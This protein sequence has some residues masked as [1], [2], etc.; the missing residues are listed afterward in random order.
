MLRLLIFVSLLLTFDPR[1]DFQPRVVAYYTS[2][3][4]YGAQY[5]VT[6]IPADKITHL[7]YAFMNV[8]ANGECVL[9]DEMADIHFLY[10]GDTEDEPIKGNLKQLMLLKQNYPHL[11]ILMSVGGA[12]WSVNFSDAALTQESRERFA[13]SCVALMQRFGFDG[14]DIDWEFPVFSSGREEDRAN[15]TLMLVELRHQLDEAGTFILTIAAPQTSQFIKDIEIDKIHPY[16]DWINVMTY[17]FH[18]GWSERTNHHAALYASSDDPSEDEDMRV[19]F[20]IDAALRTYL[21]GGVPP[22]KLVMGIPFYGHGWLGVPPEN[23]GLY[24]PFEN[25]PQGTFGT[26]IYTF[27]DI[28]ANYLGQYVRYWDDEASVSWLYN[29]T[30][31]IMISYEDEVS[32]GIKLAYMKSSDLG[33]VMIWE[34]GYD[35]AE[36]TLLNTIHEQLK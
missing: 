18:G 25:L 26:D 27:S 23:N 17:T 28:S 15:F 29:P 24:Q 8:S 9:G 22:H 30:T 32:L 12:T 20:N 16:L 14:I 36:H 7:N 13:R 19:N 6:D 10:P 5:Y 3:S 34:L 31:R 1:S 33:G 11:K 2:W 4:I 21:D 35:D